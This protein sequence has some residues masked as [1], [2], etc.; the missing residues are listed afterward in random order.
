MHVLKREIK[1][2]HILLNHINNIRCSK[3][4]EMK[5]VIHNGIR[6][7]KHS[8]L[9]HLKRYPMKHVS[10]TPLSD[11]LKQQHMLGGSEQLLSP[12]EALFLDVHICKD[13][14]LRLLQQPP[15]ETTVLML[16]KEGCIIHTNALSEAYFK[17]FCTTQIAKLK[18]SHLHH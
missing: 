13:N 10:K 6:N 17:L 15:K 1:A 16:Q 11:V 4:N 9:K 5:W 7:H 3:W 18:Q 12:M 14:R 8:H 2:S